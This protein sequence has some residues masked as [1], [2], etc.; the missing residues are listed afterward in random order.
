MVI[1]FGS[2]GRSGWYLGKQSFVLRGDY[3][4]G[5]FCCMIPGPGDCEDSILKCWLY[6]MVALILA[7]CVCVLQSAGCRETPYVGLADAGLDA[8]SCPADA[9]TAPLDD[10]PVSGLWSWEWVDNPVGEDCGSGCVQLTFAQNVA[11]G[12]WDIWEDYLVYRD[13]NQKIVVVDIPGGRHLVIPDLHPE[14]PIGTG[15]SAGYSPA[16]FEDTVFYV[17]SVYGAAPARLEVV[18]VELGSERQNVVW[19]RDAAF[20]Y[21][22]ARPASM[23]VYGPRLVSAGGGGDG[24]VASLTVYAPPW[25]AEG[26]VLI[27][28]E[29]GGWNS[30]WENTLVFWDQRQTPTSIG[31]YDF[32][33]GQFFSVGTDNDYQ[34]APRIQGTKIVYM[35]FR[36]G[37]SDPWGSWE[38][39]AIAMYD[40]ASG[41][42][43]LIAGGFFITAHP[44][45]WEDTVVWMDYRKSLNQS[46]EDLGAVEIWGFDSKTKKRFQITDLPG[47]P[48]A[49][50][51]IWGDRVF[52]LMFDRRFL[53]GN[54]YM[55]D[56]DPSGE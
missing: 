3:R 53:S 9:G 10:A 54:V 41:Q 43:K 38:N 28:E 46:R 56:V 23:D 11:E 8:D 1:L 27:G 14:F 7:V 29:Y 25:P 17:L 32:E 15:R 12:E 49:Y 5:R 6:R 36:F 50:P 34:Y 4:F 40:L 33:T 22:R 42:T 37:D 18:K 48:K 24:Q 21:R 30:I 26:Q 51:R 31:G 35:D 55:F 52:V 45:V 19:E 20:G 13:E 47:R 2:P 44:D 39:S 16:I